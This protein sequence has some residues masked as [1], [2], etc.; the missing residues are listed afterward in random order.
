MTW[1]SVAGSSAILLG[2]VACGGETTN[3]AQSTKLLA[4]TTAVAATPAFGV[5]DS[6]GILT[7]SSG[8]GLVF[9]VGAGGSI[10]S[11]TYNGGPELQDQT[12]GSHI[13]SGIGAAVSYTND[14]SVIKITLTTASLVHYLLVKQN[15]NTIYMGTYVTAEPTVG[16]L[17]WITRLKG[18][19]FTSVPVESNNAGSTGDIESSDVKGHADGTTTSKYY[20]N[21]RAKDLTIRG[22]TGSGVGAFMVYG[23]RETSSGG[24]FYR[25]IQNQSGGGVEVYNYMN[26]GHAQT[27]AWRTGFFGP[28]ALIFNDGSTAPAIPDMSWM[29]DYCLS[30]WVGA[31]GRG[32]V[33][34]TGLSGMDPNYSYT[35]GF[36]NTTAQYWADVSPTGGFSAAGMKAGTYSMT[37]YKN[38]LAVYTEQ[39]TVDAGA[40]TTMNNRSITGDP[41]TASAL[42]RIGDWDGTPLEFLNGT[43]FNVRHPSDVRNASWAVT[44]FNVGDPVNTFPAALWQNTV[45]NNPLTV[46]F[47]LTAAQVASHTVR[48]GITT[49]NA[50]GRPKI[51]VNGWTSSIPAASSQPSS[52]TLTVGTYRGNN[53]MFTYSVPASAFVAG[54]NTM[55]IYVSSGSSGTAFLSP[56]YSFDALDM[57]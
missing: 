2:L 13:N 33:S 15:D 28:Y 4:S 47:N 35:V 10:T 12:K 19:E 48:I 5:T 49:A 25:D 57:L 45:G 39:V 18:T 52:R 32:Q 8:A 17:R 20:G 36:A 7:V 3:E 14:G 24:P 9:K 46:T 41:S 30:G 37:V 38:E 22:V 44:G 43:S 6:G 50:G 51:V 55:T 56:S 21:Q 27:E 1:R 31:S 53:K 29:G 40:T 11:I 26:S 42:W 54:T 23:N 16:E 34:G